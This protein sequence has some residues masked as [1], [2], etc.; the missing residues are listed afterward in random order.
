MIKLEEWADETAEFY[1][2]IATSAP[3]YDLAF[4][5]QSDLTKLSDSP[6]IL[7][8]GIN[9]GSGGKYT[10]HQI[11]KKVWKE[12]GVNGRMDGATLLKGNPDFQNR[13]KWRTWQ[14]LKRIFS[15]GEISDIIRDESKFAWSNIIF[16]NEPKEE[17]DNQ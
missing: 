13:E 16:F 9:P 7:L 6:E 3:I 15:Y 2:N 10:E 14:G 17:T 11:E 1:H 12:W 5:T 8:L 4:Y